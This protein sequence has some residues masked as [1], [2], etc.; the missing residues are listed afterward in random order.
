MQRLE[1]WPLEKLGAEVVGLP[2]VA[3]AQH[4]H[5]MGSASDE[6]LDACFFERTLKVARRRLVANQC[7]EFG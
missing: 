1:M 5:P 2:F 7:G 4:S 6:N 3:A